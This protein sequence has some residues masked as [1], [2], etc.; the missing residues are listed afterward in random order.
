MASLGN[1][2]FISFIL[3]MVPLKS[4]LL[5]IHTVKIIHGPVVPCHS[6]NRCLAG[7]TFANSP[8]FVKLKNPSILCQK[9]ITFEGS[10]RGYSWLKDDI[11]LSTNP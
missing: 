1:N 7:L 11:V 2:N 3:H 8:F 6:P 4:G 10:H 9:V 5:L